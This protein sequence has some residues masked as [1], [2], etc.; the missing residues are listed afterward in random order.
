MNAKRATL[1]PTSAIVARTPREDSPVRRAPLFRSIALLIWAAT[2]IGVFYG[3]SR[4]ESLALAQPSASP[5]IEWVDLPPWLTSPDWQEVLREVEARVAFMPDDRVD[6]PE[7]CRRVAEAIGSSPRVASV[8]RVWKRGDG[9]VRVKAAFRRP[10]ALVAW[11]DTAHLVDEQGIRLPDQLTLA[12]VNQERWYVVEGVRS[13]A[14]PGDGQT[15]PGEDL[16]A[17]L[18]LVRFLREAEFSGALPAP[19]RAV[20]RGVDV[21]QFSGDR[22]GG[23]LRIRTNNPRTYLQWGLPPGRGLGV[24]ATAERKIELLRAFFARSGGLPDVA[25]IDLRDERGVGLPK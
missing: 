23:C 1:R 6:D 15:W 24:E 25:F 19:V 20:L 14:P 18:E 21:S 13:P 4:L 7:L 22:I 12:Q 10:L 3:L 2:L 8:E 16:A 17:G 11:R 9:L 5:R